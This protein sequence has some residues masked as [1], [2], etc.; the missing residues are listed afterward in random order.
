[1][2]TE[3]DLF[4]VEIEQLAEEDVRLARGALRALSGTPGESVQKF[5]RGEDWLAFVAETYGSFRDAPIERG[6]QGKLET[7]D[8]LG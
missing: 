1:M 5:P 4:R 7:R 2:P 8:D 6:P 3:R